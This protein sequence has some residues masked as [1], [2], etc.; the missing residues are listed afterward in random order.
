MAVKIWSDVGKSLER[1]VN[2]TAYYPDFIPCNEFSLLLGIVPKEVWYFVEVIPLEQIPGT[3]YTVSSLQMT[4]SPIFLAS[5]QPACSWC[6]NL[7]A[8]IV[9]LSY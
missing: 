9:V 8:I 5:Y 3:F 6:T 4:T 2:I 7:E 1:V